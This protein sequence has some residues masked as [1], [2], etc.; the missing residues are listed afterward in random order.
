MSNKPFTLFHTSDTHGTILGVDYARKSQLKYGLSRVFTYLKT[1]KKKE[2]VYIDSGDIIQ[3]NALAYYL[4][5]SPHPTHPFSDVFNRLQCD[6]LTLG[7]HDFNFGQD[8]LQSFTNALNATVLNANVFQD[9]QPFIGQIS[10]I[11]ILDNGFKIGFIGATTHYIPNWETKENIENL[12]FLDAFTSVKQEVAHLRDK[13]D[14]IVVNY[15][16][17]LEGSIDDFFETSLTG[18]NQG[19][20]M[21]KDIP[22]IDILLTGHQH[23]MIL[24]PVNQTILSQPGMNA[25]WVHAITIPTDR[26]FHASQVTLKQV[27]MESYEEDATI[28]RSMEPFEKAA[29]SYLDQP[30]G[31]FDQAYLIDDP[32]QARLYKHPLVTW[33]NQVQ[34]KATGADIALCGLGNEVTG[35]NETVTLREILATYIYPNILVVKEVTGRAIKQALEKTAAFFALENNQ[36]TIAP[37]FQ[38]PKKEYYNYDMYDPVTYTIDV[39]RPIGQRISDLK[40]QQRPLHMNHVYKVAMNNYRAAGG[41]DYAMYKNAPLVFDTQKEIVELLIEAVQESPIIT[42]HDPLNITIKGN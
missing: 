11:K 22:G 4:Y 41:G 37:S 33:I 19:L 1:H 28:T 25:E 8:H 31:R 24:K 6:Y 14:V 32:L 35:F 29:Q 10:A 39:T 12:T 17:G 23:Q 30:I 9:N 42:L 7:N 26:P 27:S 34:L 38:T 13:V 16:G 3:G 2:D 20:K 5:K 36:I 40:L 21:L 18:E 15:H